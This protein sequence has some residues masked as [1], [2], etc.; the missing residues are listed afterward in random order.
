[1]GKK[2]K[3]QAARQFAYQGKPCRTS[4]LSTASP[5]TKP[6]MRRISGWMGRDTF[7]MNR[8]EVYFALL[9]FFVQVGIPTSNIQQSFWLGVLCWFVIVCLAVHMV[10]VWERAAAWRTAVKVALSLSIVFL[11]FLFVFAPLR[12]QWQVDHQLAR[13]EPL[14]ELILLT[15]TE[16]PLGEKPS[17]LP[18]VAQLPLSASRRP[19]FG[20]QQSRRARAVSLPFARGS[21]AR[22]WRARRAQRYS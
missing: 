2:N 11:I 4:S 15:I 21:S 12:K 13:R 6:L 14:P 19:R 1:M 3:R 18:G 20:A 22:A 10:W 17:Q 5:D 7:G 9:L 16:S 8:L